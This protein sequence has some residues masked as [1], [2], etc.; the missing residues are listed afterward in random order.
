MTNFSK[1]VAIPIEE[2]EQLKSSQISSDPL[3]QRMKQYE[4][5]YRQHENIPLPDI[6]QKQQS[7]TLHHMLTLAEQIKDRAL[8]STPSTYRRRAQNLFD[9]INPF[10]KWNEKGEIMNAFGS[11]I[12]GSHIEDLVQYAVR[13]KRRSN[14]NPVGW[15][16]FLQELKEHNV[17]KM[18]LGADTIV[19]LDR[20]RPSADPVIFPLSNASSKKRRVDEGLK[21]L[22]R[23]SLRIAKRR[24]LAT[25]RELASLQ[26][27]RGYFRKNL[28][29]HRKR[30]SK[31]I[32]ILKWVQ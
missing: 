22:P 31:Q 1:M 24:S 16:F 9:F 32:T 6:Q 23:K 17:P 27:G 21:T 29:K 8:A 19:E 30:H 7:K 14:I 25:G 15:E 28:D 5:E 11:P 12:S 4:S 10:I 2:Y 20:L 26:S 13:D 18:S 3:D